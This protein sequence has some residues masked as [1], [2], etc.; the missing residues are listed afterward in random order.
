MG[1]LLTKFPLIRLLKKRDSYFQ[2]FE[3]NLI[4][5]FFVLIVNVATKVDESPSA[6]H[7]LSFE[8]LSFR[9]E[10]TVSTTFLTKLVMCSVEFPLKAKF[11]VG[12]LLPKGCNG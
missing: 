4:S 9:G 3:L 5:N 12:D 10:T 6:K 8:Y 11:P 1:D 7:R 2:G